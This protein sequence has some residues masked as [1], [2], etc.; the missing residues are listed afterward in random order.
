MAHLQHSTD[1]PSCSEG[2]TS[3][4]WPVNS[5]VP[6]GSVLGPA[7]LNIFNTSLEIG[8]KCSISKFADDTKLEGAVDSPERPKALQMYLDRSERQAMINGMKFKKLKCW[9]LHQARS[10]TRHKCKI[11]EKWQD[12]RPAESNLWVLADIKLSVTQ[13]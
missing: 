2:V 4:W 6:Q 1:E 8:F 10:N 3:G 11:G 5:A 13:P 9:I 12:S 7:L